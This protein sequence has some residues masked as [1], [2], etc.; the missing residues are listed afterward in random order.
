MANPLLLFLALAAPTPLLYPLDQAP[1]VTATLGTSRIGHHH[2][3][4]DL[5][6]GGR[7]DA[8]VLATLDGVIYKIRRS[9]GGYGRSVYVRHADGLSS[10]YGHL[11]RFSNELEAVALAE[12]GRVRAYAFDKTLDP[13]ITVARGAMLGYCG[14][15]GTDLVHLHFELRRDG[16][17]IN[18]LTNG[19][20][21]PDREAPR[22]VRLRLVPRTAAA[23]VSGGH[24]VVDRRL[25]G[26]R[27]P[28]RRLPGMR[29]PDRVIEVHGDV[30]LEV[31]VQDRIEGSARG[32]EPYRISLEL[33]GRRVHQILYERAS[34]ADKNI[35]ELDYEP[36]QRASRR[37]RFHKLYRE[38]PAIGPVPLA[39]ASPLLRL[40]PGR[41][42]VRLVAQDARG[43][44]SKVMVELEVV[45]SAE[46]CLLRRWEAS[47]RPAAETWPPP[48]PAAFE[49]RGGTLLVDFG[50]LCGSLDLFDVTLDEVPHAG[51][52]VT[53]F[54]GRPALALDIPATGG[55]LRLLRQGAGGV[56]RFDLDLHGL[57]NGGDVSARDGSWHVRVGADALFFPYAISAPRASTTN[58]AP[59]GHGLVPLTPLFDLAPQWR[60]TR[61]NSAFDISVPNAMELRHAGLY[62]RERGSYWFMG[63][64]L[65]PGADQ[66]RVGGAGVHVG[67]IAVLRDVSPPSIGLPVIVAHPLGSEV[68]VPLSDAG[69]GLDLTTLRVRL[70][71]HVVYPEY[72]AAFGRLSLRPGAKVATD[73]RARRLSLSIEIKDRS[74][75]ES[76]RSSTVTWP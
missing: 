21:L 30:G 8:K 74:G 5:V 4:L 62:F 60:P 27:Q 44:E 17:P 39:E 16:V 41:H 50:D 18:P 12:E 32:L 42:K 66:T 10:V 48:T 24:D 47:A 31:E 26:M 72:E 61:A 75:H 64:E 70:G 65:V 13:P 58:L 57:K 11:E 40:S 76:S 59:K 15:S 6:P 25:P 14:T 68:H 55:R 38:G 33:D 56:R 73:S 67:S 36:E 51:V 46:P 71:G 37:G 2:A 69:S 22:F 29:Q 52:S 49:W 7:L 53:R 43:N 45:P 9:H 20:S 34:Y 1:S 28:D 63:A 19:L 23:R 3:G 54:D 35:T